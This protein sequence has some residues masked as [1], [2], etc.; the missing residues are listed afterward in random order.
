MDE[1]NEAARLKN[2]SLPEPILITTNGII[3]AGMGRWRAAVF[4][5]RQELNSIEYSLSDDE[6]LQFILTNHGIRRGWNPTRR[7]VHTDPEPRSSN[8]VREIASDWR[9]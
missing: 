6:A 8:S 5:G 7:C 2:P 4:D 3:L 1:F 9:P